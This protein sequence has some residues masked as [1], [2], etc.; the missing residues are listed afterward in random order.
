MWS[1][2]P[3]KSSQAYKLFL[4]SEIE[5]TYFKQSAEIGLSSVSLLLITLT[6]RKG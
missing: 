4:T 6:E 1:A 5:A 3:H 2:K